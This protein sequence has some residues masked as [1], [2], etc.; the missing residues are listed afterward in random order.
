M[1]LA[2]KHDQNWIESFAVERFAA[3]SHFMPATIPLVLLCLL[4]AANGETRWRLCLFPLLIGLLGAEN[5]A[6]TKRAISK[7]SLEVLV[8]S[9]LA[10]TV[11]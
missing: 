11:S 6:A 5:L 4:L 1:I 2:P 3:H 9:C 10:K 8:R 7:S